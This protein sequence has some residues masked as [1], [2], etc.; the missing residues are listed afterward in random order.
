ML[1]IFEL[2]FAGKDFEKKIFG[3]TAANLN[4]HSQVK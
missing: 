4:W 1:E 3:Y 2:H